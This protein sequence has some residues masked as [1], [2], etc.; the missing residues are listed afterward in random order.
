MRFTSSNGKRVWVGRPDT[1]RR[2][3]LTACVFVAATIVIGLV[4]L[5]SPTIDDPSLL[6]MEAVA[7]AQAKV[8]QA[9]APAP[10]PLE[11]LQ[12][13]AG[14]CV[15]WNG[16]APGAPAG[17]GGGGPAP[18]P[19]PTPPPTPKIVYKQP[20][21]TTEC[22]QRFWP[23]SKTVG[24]TSA[25]DPTCASDIV[26]AHV[27]CL[28]GFH[29]T[30]CC[31]TPLNGAC[32]MPDRLCKDLTGKKFQKELKRLKE[33]EDKKKDEEESHKHR[34]KQAKAKRE[35]EDERIR[36]ARIKEAKHEQEEL[37]KVQ[38]SKQKKT[39]IVASKK[40]AEDKIEIA[41]LTLEPTRFP[42]MQPTQKPVN[43]QPPCSHESC[44]KHYWIGSSFDESCAPPK[45]GHVGCVAGFACAYHHKK[46][47]SGD[48]DD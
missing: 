16:P 15:S 32:P 12:W 47:H 26:P 27:D 5:N 21:N 7:E 2:L 22:C 46:H 30:Y 33:A 13:L 10:A 25:Y 42:S 18:M 38:E 40:A 36:E 9:K 17:G 20:C 11:C 39:R 23:G 48:E 43:Y 45:Q 1:M 34:E 28:D 4:S 14:N 29:C 24:M 3:Q 6:D 37:Q 8:S 44:C 19:Y 31:K 35:E 41:Q